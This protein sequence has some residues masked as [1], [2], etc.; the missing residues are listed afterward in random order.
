MDCYY[1]RPYQHERKKGKYVFQSYFHDPSNPASLIDDDLSAVFEDQYH[2]LWIGTHNNGLELMDRA[3]G[4]FKHYSAKGGPS[5]GLSSNVIRKIKA[6]KDGKLWISTLN[7]IDIFDVKTG[8]FTVLNHVPNDPL[9]L[10]QNST[11]DI[12]KDAAGSMWVGTYYGGVNVYHANSTP[13]REYKTS[14][15]GNGI[16]SNVVSAIV[17][18]ENHNLWIGTEAEGLNYY[19]RTTGKFKAIKNEIGNP[20]SLSSNLVKAISIDKKGSVWVA[21]YEGNLDRYLPFSGTFKHYKPNTAD[22]HALNSNRIV[23]LLH[24]SRGRLWVGTRAQGVFLYN[25]AKDNFTLLNSAAYNQ[26]LKFVRTFLRI[27]QKIYG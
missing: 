2:N 12:L 6:D 17:E 7:G 10:N 1:A 21:T 3:T 19:N 15:G 20:N 26:E 27:L 13:F 16:S 8:K 23:C 22:P 24:D 18:D 11:Y 25:E 14:L 5:S 4:T 9:T